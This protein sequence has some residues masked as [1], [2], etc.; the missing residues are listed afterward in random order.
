MKPQLK[1]LQHHNIKYQW[2][3]PFSLRL[4]HQGTRISCRTA[5]ELQQALQ[6]LNLLDGNS[7]T[8]TTWRRAAS[9]SSLQNA[10]QSEARNGNHHSHKR[11]RFVSSPQGQDDSMGWWNSFLIHNSLFLLKQYLLGDKNNFK[12]WF[13]SLINCVLPPIA[14]WF[15]AHNLGCIETHIIK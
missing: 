6:D 2:G 9:G 11:G 5:E 10:P 1:E 7:T 15:M 4:T 14:P 13:N 12:Y 3:F 8:T